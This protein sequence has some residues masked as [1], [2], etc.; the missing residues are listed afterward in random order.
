MAAKIL[1]LKLEPGKDPGEFELTL[2]QT[3]LPKVQI[4]HRTVAA[5]QHRVFRDSSGSNS[6]GWLVFTQLVG[7]TPETAGE[8]PVV[9]C[10]LPLPID[11]IVKDLA[12][13][14]KL[15]VLDSIT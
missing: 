14:A 1:M 7:S 8:G 5:T 9:L 12:G 13:L 3:I 6:Y 11:E 2:K 10:E 4:L 15:T